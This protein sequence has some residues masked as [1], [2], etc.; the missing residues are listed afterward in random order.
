MNKRLPAGQIRCLI[1]LGAMLTLLPLRLDAAG[2]DLL[3]IDPTARGSALGG[4]PVAMEG[5]GSGALD[6]N[7]ASL[8]ALEMRTVSATYANHPL[9]LASG[10]A[11]YAQPISGG[12]G[13]LSLTWFT[14]GRFDRRESLDMPATGEFSADDI[15]ITAGYCRS[16]LTNLFVGTSVKLLNSRIDSYTSTVAA[17]DLGA[18]YFIPSQRIRFAFTVANL[19]TQVDRYADTGEALPLTLR[20]GGARTLEHLP[21]E[22]TATVHLE[23]NGSVMATGAG[24]FTVSDN[25]I[26]R[27]GYTTLASGLKVSGPDDSL[28]GLSAGVGVIQGRLR[29]DYSF[30][31]QGALGQVHR[32]SAGAFIP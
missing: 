12:V 16:F 3:R 20:I 19:G 29:V 7:P 6:V 5:V 13:A 24:E 14:Y 23:S 1:A 2:F 22:I 32:I 8:A 18:Q 25:L 30:H 9:D 11:A 31:S 15:Q 17:V 27:A 10:H 26:L 21:L 28:A 4:F